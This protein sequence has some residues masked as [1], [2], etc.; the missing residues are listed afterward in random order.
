MPTKLEHD[1]DELVETYDDLATE[2]SDK[3]QEIQDLLDEVDRLQQELAQHQADAAAAADTGDVE[4]AKAAADCWSDTWNALAAALA[5]LAGALGTAAGVAALATVA[6]TAGIITAVSDPVLA[7]IA[8]VLTILAGLVAILSGIAWLLSWYYGELAEDPPQPRFKKVAR[9]ARPRRLVLP[10]LVHVTGGLARLPRL[11]QRSHRLLQYAQA[12]LDAME[13][14]QG[15]RAAKDDRYARR[16]ARSLASLL[17]QANPHVEGIRGTLLEIATQLEGTGANIKITRKDLRTLQADVRKA[18]LSNETRK[19][20]RAAGL[21]D[22]QVKAYSAWLL[23]IPPNSIK[24][25]KVSWHLRQGY[26]RT[27]AGLRELGVTPTMATR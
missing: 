4:A 6:A 20:L 27:A 15:A 13:R 11:A 25:A 21:S 17:S 10:S 3:D 12:S 22:D 19:A 14:H 24:E 23:S 18:G 5:V 16:H 8:A 26:L 9:V 2:V 1:Y 7:S